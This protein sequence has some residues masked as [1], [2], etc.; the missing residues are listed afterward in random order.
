M[1]QGRSNKW[2]APATPPLC[3][4]LPLSGLPVSAQSTCHQ[5]SPP[6]LPLSP[7]TST[8]THMRV[9]AHMWVEF[10]SESNLC[11]YTRVCTHTHT[12]T[13]T[14]AHIHTHIHAHAHTHTHSSHTNTHSFPLSFFTI[15]MNTEVQWHLDRCKSKNRY[16]TN[17]RI[18]HYFNLL[19]SDSFLAFQYWPQT[20]THTHMH[21]Q[22][23]SI[24]FSGQSD[25]H[26]LL[27]W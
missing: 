18:K 27:C 9:C 24:N 7:H 22:S 1:G 6:C 15:I 10:W 11:T 23:T 16:I 19:Q 26:T 2:I 4:L 25:C 14:R 13:H 21:A 8:H 17:M 5:V 12:H 20:H 3:Q